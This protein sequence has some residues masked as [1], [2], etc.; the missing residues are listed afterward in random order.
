MVVWGLI[1]AFRGRYYIPDPAEA[2][3]EDARMR[4]QF[5][6]RSL[7]AALIAVGLCAATTEVAAQAAPS[8]CPRPAAATQ[9]AAT[10]SGATGTGARVGGRHLA[11]SDWT[12]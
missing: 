3:A 12:W 4:E 6:R 7:A 5:V 10:A 11:P 8:A 1:G 2:L 9:G